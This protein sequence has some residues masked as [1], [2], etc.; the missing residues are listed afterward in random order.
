M[1]HAVQSPRK[2]TYDDLVAMFPDEDG[3]C[4]ELIDGVLYVTA[5]PFTRH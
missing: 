2:L 3:L 1:L 4:R 5:S